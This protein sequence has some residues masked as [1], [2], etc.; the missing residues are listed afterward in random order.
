MEPFALV[1]ASSLEYFELRPWMTVFPEMLAG[2]TSRKGG[3]SG[4]PYESLNL[5][6][7]VGDS[8]DAV[9]SNRQRLAEE[10]GVPF[11][12]WTCAEQ[13]HGNSIVIINS[14]DRGKGRSNRADAIQA[15]DG[16]LTNERNLLLTAYFADCVP[17]YFYDPKLSVIGLAHAGWKGTVSCIAGEMIEQMK[18]QFGSNPEDIIAAIGPSI[19]QC[20]YE[21]DDVVANQVRRIIAPGGEINIA[22]FEKENNKYM[23]DLRESNRQILLKAGIL[24]YHIELTRRCTSCQN[25]L[26]YSHRKERGKTG[27]MAAWIGLRS[28]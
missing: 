21:V 24:P 1:E 5:G 13:V 12:S 10:L 11:S 17:L 2:F 26:F 23:L 3:K 19:G 25:E 20:C 15:V 18:T 22:I 7:H 14:A 6:L 8:D 28:E 16:L 27:R 4:Q 9:V